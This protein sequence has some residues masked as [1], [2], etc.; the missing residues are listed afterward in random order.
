MSAVEPSHTDAAHADIGIVCALPMELAPF[1]DRCRRVRKYTGGEFTFRGG[2]Y[3]EIRVVVAQ[4]GIGFAR[5][6][7]ATRALI[8]AHSPPWIL[9]SGFCGGLRPDVHVGDIVLANSI[10]DQHGQELRVDMKLPG[11]PQDGLHLGRIVTTDAMIRTIAE[12]ERLAGEHKAIACDMESLAVAQVCRDQH[13]RFLAIR[14][15]SDDLSADLPPEVFA[16]VGSTGSMR[17]GAALGAAW[18]RP[19]SVKVM[20]KLRE[21]AQLAS[22]RLATF[23]EGTVTQLY[24]ARH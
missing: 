6:R 12:K 1:L 10:V 19:E 24:D 11:D 3:G 17:F 15:V 5:A 8:E 16:V 7:E 20:W 13:V 2:L 21:Q 23:L 9:S 4:S 22:E 18:K 14:S